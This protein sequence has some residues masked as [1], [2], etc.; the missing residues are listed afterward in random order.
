MSRTLKSRE[1]CV[2]RLAISMWSIFL[3]FQLEYLPDWFFNQ[4]K[5]GEPSCR[6]VC[7]QEYNQKGLVFLTNYLSRKAQELDACPRACLCFYWD[8]FA[9]QVVII[10]NVKRISREEAVK[11]FNRKSFETRITSYISRQGKVIK[12]KQVN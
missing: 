12:S 11:C 5:R 10:G 8:T 9:R 7:I 2:W 6:M 1:L 4:F 3:K